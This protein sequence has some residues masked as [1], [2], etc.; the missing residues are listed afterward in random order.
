MAFRL[1]ARGRGTLITV[2]GL[3]KRFGVFPALKGIDLDV[4]DG[5][6]LALLGPSGSGKTT[7]LRIIAGL[8][9]LDAGRVAFNG[10][11]VTGLQAADRTAGFVFQHYARV[12]HLTAAVKLAFRLTRRR[13]GARPP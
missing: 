5:E 7:L 10:E 6:F 2:N 9:F 3:S 12:S 11:H 13:H 4:R 1:S 8:E